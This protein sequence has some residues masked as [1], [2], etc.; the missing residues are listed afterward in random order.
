MQTLNT[1]TLATCFTILEK[2]ARN[3]GLIMCSCK[4]LC[5]VK[6]SV[7]VFC[8]HMCKIVINMA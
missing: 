4:G 6:T 5:L 2:Q 7:E 3:A 1:R 8:M